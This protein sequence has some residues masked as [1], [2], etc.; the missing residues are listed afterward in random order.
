MAPS[1][2]RTPQEGDSQDNRARTQAPQMD[3]QQRSEWHVALR[4]RYA[5]RMEAIRSEFQTRISSTPEDLMNALEAESRLFNRTLQLIRDYNTEPERI[6]ASIQVR[7]Y[8]E[9]LPPPLPI[10]ILLPISNTAM[11]PHQPLATS[12]QPPGEERYERRDRNRR[13]RLEDTTE[14]FED[15]AGVPQMREMMGDSSAHRTHNTLDLNLTIT[16]GPSSR[17]EE[18]QSSNINQISQHMREFMARQARQESRSNAL[19]SLPHLERAQPLF[20]TVG[21]PPRTVLNTLAQTSPQEDDEPD[22]SRIQRSTYHWHPSI[23]S[24]SPSR[25]VPGGSVPFIHVPPTIDERAPLNIVHNR[26]G[27]IPFDARH[28][29]PEDALSS[30][31]RTS[32]TVAAPSSSQRLAPVEPARRSDIM[33][34]LNDDEPPNR[35]RGLRPTRSMGQTPQDEQH[36]GGNRYTP[37]FPVPAPGGRTSFTRIPDPLHEDAMFDAIIDDDEDEIPHMLSINPSPAPSH[38]STPSLPLTNPAVPTFIDLPR[39]IASE[40]IRPTESTM[41]MLYDEYLTAS[42]PGPSMILAED[43][44]TSDPNSMP[45]LVTPSPS[46]S[47][48]VLPETHFPR[49][50]ELVARYYALT[51]E[52]SRSIHRYA[53]TLYNSDIQSQHPHLPHISTLRPIGAHFQTPCLARHSEGIDL[54]VSFI[55]AW[56]SQSPGIPY[57]VLDSSIEGFLKLLME[58]EMEAERDLWYEVV[59]LHVNVDL[60][61]WGENEEEEE[62]WEED[63]RD[64][65][66]ED[67]G[68]EM[69][70]PVIGEFMSIP[71]GPVGTQIQNQTQD[72]G[73]SAPGTATTAPTSQA[74]LAQ[75]PA[76]QESLG[77]DD[78]NGG[79]YELLR[80]FDWTYLQ[81]RDTDNG[82]SSNFGTDGALD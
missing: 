50:Q 65:V 4:Q 2:F 17:Q 75:A 78:L 49:R 19:P 28:L 60:E 16:H 45:A 62:E 53:L 38:S 34:L 71:A 47:S 69:E 11:A 80:G 54:L 79:N 39:D 32:S 25:P 35:P 52:Y 13:R 26:Q 15:N 31:S 66:E 58:E 59:R 43:L 81:Y 27:N 82:G 33:A 30:S 29:R 7:E 46:T 23:R 24:A 20:A 12:S 57:A 48:T 61:D 36:A 18:S 77:F 74:A 42:Q 10:R 55:Y 67:E 68:E 70:G 3:A 72:P 21:H 63:G 5:D 1:I 37:P 51:P 41:S 64:G 56:Q 44:N 40:P 9:N 22:S 8:L 6:I 14:I 73:S 76:T